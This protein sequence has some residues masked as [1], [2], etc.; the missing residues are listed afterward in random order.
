MVAAFL[1]QWIR[2]TTFSVLFLLM[3]TTD[4][5]CA[6]HKFK[7]LKH[8]S[9]SPLYGQVLYGHPVL[10]RQQYGVPYSAPIAHYSPNVPVSAPYVIRPPLPIYPPPSYLPPAPSYHYSSPPQ[11]LTPPQYYLPPPA[12]SYSPSYPPPVPSYPHSAPSYEPSVP[13]YPHSAPSYE[14][15][16]L[17][18]DPPAS[19]YPPSAPLYPPTAISHSPP[20]LSYDSPALTVPSYEHQIPSPFYESEPYN[21][22]EAL[23][24]QQGLGYN[25]EAPTY[26]IDGLLTPGSDLYVPEVPHIPSN[27]H[28]DETSGDESEGVNFPTLFYPVKNLVG[29]HFRPGFKYNPRP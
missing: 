21:H 7:G 20:D 24:Q 27:N 13:S 16:A 26:G 18:F 1:T 23:A 6:S 3:V 11:A 8:R 19:L 14:P 15:Q 28:I 2:S 25:S 9:P 17:S 29:N 22:A 10:P 4:P 5:T 12:L